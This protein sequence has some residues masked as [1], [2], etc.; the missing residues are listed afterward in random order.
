[1][2]RFISPVVAGESELIVFNG[3]RDKTS[4]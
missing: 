2:L 1:M 3:V 4:L